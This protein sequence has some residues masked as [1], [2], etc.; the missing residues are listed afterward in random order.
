MLNQIDEE[1]FLGS[2]TASGRD[3]ASMI[4]GRAPCWDRRRKVADLGTPTCGISTGW[5]A[6]LLGLVE[7]RIGDPPSSPNPERLKGGVLKDGNGG[8]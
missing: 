5:P 3:V 7:H 8:W 4:A 2:A 1:D 6:C